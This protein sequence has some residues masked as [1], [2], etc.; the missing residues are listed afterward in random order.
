MDSRWVD[1]I[2]ISHMASVG[3]KAA[4]VKSKKRVT[5]E[6]NYMEIKTFGVVFSYRNIILSLI[7]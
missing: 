2:P 7:S 1:N 6:S 4:I 3:I 5:E